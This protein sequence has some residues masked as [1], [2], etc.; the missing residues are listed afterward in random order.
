MRMFGAARN[1]AIAAAALGGAGAAAL[2]DFSYTNFSSVGGLAMVGVATQNS[3][4]VLLTPSIG[5]S[6]G[7][8]WAAAKQDISGGFD[9]TLTIQIEDRVGG[10]A[11]GIAL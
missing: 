6:A 4:R 9:T 10:G 3:N 11:D 1:M 5:A 2:A 8:V 7:A